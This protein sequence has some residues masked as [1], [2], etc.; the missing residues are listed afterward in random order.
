[1]S[2]SHIVHFEVDVARSAFGVGREHDDGCESRKD[3]ELED[4]ELLEPWSKV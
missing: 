1:M 4:V 2:R 3:L